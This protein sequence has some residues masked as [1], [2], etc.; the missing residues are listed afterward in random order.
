MLSANSKILV[1]VEYNQKA[2]VEIAGDKILLAK[3]Y[4]TNRRESEPVV[5]KVID[6]NG[7]VPQNTF[8]LV[9]HNR[10]AEHSPHHLG[11]NQYSLAYNESIFASVD[12]DGNAT[13]LC[14]NIFVEH[15][16]DND[17]SLIP[18]H[19]KKPNEYKYKV[20]SDGF[21][22]IKGD[23]IFCLDFSDYEIVYVFKG[24]EYRVIKIKKS[25]IVG[26]VSK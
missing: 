16:Y 3:E 2:S 26:K 22:Y 10:F 13:G 4:S 23:I 7:Y 20:I 6:N 15:I 25:D 9:H 18:Q 19:L 17:S 8:L 21:G 1:E 5:C 24:V 12:E 14:D 11:G